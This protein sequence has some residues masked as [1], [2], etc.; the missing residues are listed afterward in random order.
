[1]MD[2]AQ[3]AAEVS[4]ICSEEIAIRVMIKTW[5]LAEK[6]GADAVLDGFSTVPETTKRWLIEGMDDAFN[7]DSPDEMHAVA[8]INGEVCISGTV[9]TEWVRAVVRRIASELAY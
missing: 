6:E 1:M 9:P 2:A 7:E 5:L 3:I 8:A 4:R